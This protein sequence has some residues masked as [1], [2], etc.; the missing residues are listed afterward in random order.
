MRKG[1]LITLEGGDGCG[2]TTLLQGI[3]SYFLAKEIPCIV[4]RAPG[5][6]PL[7]AQIRSL[8]LQGEKVHRLTELF[9]FLADR[10]EHVEQVIKKALLQGHV[11]LCDRFHDSTIAYQGARGFDPDWIRSMCLLASEG[12][13]PALTFYLDLDPQV[14]LE[15]AC[16]ASGSKDRLESEALDFHQNI[17]KAFQHMAAQEPKRMHLLDALQS[18]TQILQQVIHDIE[19]FFSSYR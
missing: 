6:T 16:R 1:C 2:K 7:G 3:A 15:R 9:L 4:T 13:E 14:G 18:P 19:V 10:A 12:I 17:R 5:G 11:V 8:L